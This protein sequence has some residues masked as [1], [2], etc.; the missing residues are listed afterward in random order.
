VVS[1][2]NPRPGLT[3]IEVEGRRIGQIRREYGPRSDTAFFATLFGQDQIFER[4]ADAARHLTAILNRAGAAAHEREA[5][6]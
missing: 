2:R 6:K 4:R 5:I 3:V 1:W